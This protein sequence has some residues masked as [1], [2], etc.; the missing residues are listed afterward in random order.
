MKTVQV[1]EALLSLPLGVYPEGELLDQKIIL[2]LIFWGNILSSILH[3]Q[4][5]HKGSDFSA[6]LSAAAPVCL[7]RA[8]LMAVQGYLIV[9]AILISQTVNNVEGLLMCLLA[10]CLASL[11]THVLKSFAHF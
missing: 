2:Y 7:A 6:S 1:A 4:Q 10:F 11:E 8:I 9:A 5:Q 3:S